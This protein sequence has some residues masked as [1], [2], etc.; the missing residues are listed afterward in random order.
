MCGRLFIKPVTDLEKLLQMLGIFG[1]TLPV[2]NNLAPSESVPVLHR[3]SE[4]FAV[5]EMRWWL[6]PF[7]SPEEPS[8]KFAM[9]N[10]RIE[11][12]LTSRAFREP[13]RHRR[14]I[15]PAAGFVE[16]KRDGKNKQPYFIEGRDQPLLLAGIWDV[17][18]D[19]LMSCA[20]ITQAAN[21]EFSAVHDRMPL[22]LDIPEMYRWLD[23]DVSV[24]NLIHEFTGAS[25]KLRMRPISSRVNNARN[26]SEPEFIDL[27]DVALI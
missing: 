8:Q 17:W 11:T 18:R 12:V 2:L 16:W 21:E 19:Q 10:A 5:S 24:E 9:F 22:S 1:V 14:C 23:P 27:D 26:K 7:W 15:I 6:H 13:V 4:G 20:I 25:I 3:T